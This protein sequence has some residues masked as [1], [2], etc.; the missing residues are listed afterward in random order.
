MRFLSSVILPCEFLSYEDRPQEMRLFSLQ[1]RRLR[2]NLIVA[3]QYVKG[4][5]KK[6]GDGLL[7]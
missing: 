2:G 5:Y 4:A 7:T 3:F 6:E 1:K